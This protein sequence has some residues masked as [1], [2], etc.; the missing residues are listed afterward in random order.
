MEGELEGIDLEV[1]RLARDLEL[2][3]ENIV[4]KDGVI[5]RIVDRDG[6]ITF[7]D[8][9]EGEDKEVVTTDAVVGVD[10]NTATVPTVKLSL[11]SKAGYDL[12]NFDYNGKK[13]DALTPEDEEQILLGELT[14]DRNTFQ[15]QV[16]VDVVNFLRTGKSLQQLADYVYENDPK[17]AASKM[18]DADLVKRSLKESFP[19]F[20]EEELKEEFDKMDEGSINRRAT[21]LALRMKVENKE[22]DLG[23]VSKED[24][25][26]KQE[27]HTV[28]VKELVNATNEVESIAGITLTDE[29]RNEIL[30]DIATEQFDL[31]SNLINDLTNPDALIEVSFYRLYVPSIIE[32]FKKQVEDVSKAKYEEG[33]NA[34]LGKLPKS[35]LVEVMTD[36]RPKELKIERE[37]EV[38]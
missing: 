16:E 13:L 36:N 38:F 25:R 7:T 15:S 27:Q 10:N 12:T 34:A 17:L 35:K 22:V 26:I 11:L 28:L 21:A 37:E 31:D 1:D 29:M 23:K 18:S 6:N 30:N 32:T 33:Y 5:D 2:P 19:E 14:K 20:T 24:S 9:E 8:Y 4:V 3:K